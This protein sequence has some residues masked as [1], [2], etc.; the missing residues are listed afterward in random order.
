MKGSFTVKLTRQQQKFNQNPRAALNQ[1]SKYDAV[2]QRYLDAQAAVRPPRPP[3]PQP[4]PWT[5]PTV[6]SQQITYDMLQQAYQR[7]M[8]SL[9][10]QPVIVV[11][12]RNA[13]YSKHAQVLQQLIND[14]FFTQS[15]LMSYGNPRRPIR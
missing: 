3:K 6:T 15:P 7:A 8:A 12:A 14:V 10:P 5:T 4:V 11:K 13:G 1:A 2:K 9:P